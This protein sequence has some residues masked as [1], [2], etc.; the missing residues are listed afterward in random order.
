MTTPKSIRPEQGPA[1]VW[2]GR[3][4]Q[5]HVVYAEARGAQVEVWECQECRSLVSDLKGHTRAHLE[6]R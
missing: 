3:L 6:T 1:Y 2:K 5:G 4:V